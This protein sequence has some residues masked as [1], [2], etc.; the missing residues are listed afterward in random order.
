MRIGAAGCCALGVLVRAERP[1]RPMAARSR[2]E[3]RVF[4][5]SVSGI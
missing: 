5:I 2:Q 1:V 3:I 4:F